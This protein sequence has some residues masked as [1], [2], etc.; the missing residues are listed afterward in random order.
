LLPELIFSDLYFL[1]LKQI[2]EA[3]NGDNYDTA[4][5]TKLDSIVV[6]ALDFHQYAF[7]SLS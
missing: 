1:P 7:S 4:L 3:P 2:S 5:P 6:R